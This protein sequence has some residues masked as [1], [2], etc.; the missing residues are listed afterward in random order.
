MHAGYVPK[1]GD[2]VINTTLRDND[3]RPVVAMAA[4]ARLVMDRALA[5]KGR[6]T[7]FKPHNSPSA[8]IDAIMICQ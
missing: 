1:A 7:A 2:G 6:L 5:S 8:H 4:T 3:V